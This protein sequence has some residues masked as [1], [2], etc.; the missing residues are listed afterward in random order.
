MEVGEQEIQKMT[1]EGETCDGATDSCPAGELRGAGG[2][3]MDLEASAG[4]A[5]EECCGSGKTGGDVRT[6]EGDTGG[7]S[8]MD[9]EEESVFKVT[10]G[11]QTGFSGSEELGGE[12]SRGSDCVNLFTPSPR[13][14]TLL[15]VK[16]GVLYM[17]GGIYEDGDR[18]VTLADMY[19]LNLDRIDEWNTII[20]SNVKDLVSSLLTN[21]NL[22]T[23][24]LYFQATIFLY[25]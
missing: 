10:V 4:G 3:G 21:A 1:I 25:S 12:G 17:Y 7:N 9:T 5:G 24:N 2:S 20:E 8:A 15:A 6:M 16:G 14:N 13:M 22:K 23:L 11:P 18:Q 19:S